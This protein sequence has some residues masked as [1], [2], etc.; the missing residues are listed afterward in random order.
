M[1]PIPGFMTKEQREAIPF[2]D[3]NLI[4]ENG[5]IRTHGVILYQQCG[6]ISDVMT[7]DKICRSFPL[8]FKKELVEEALGYIYALVLCQSPLFENEAAALRPVL[9]PRLYDVF[10]AL[11]V[12]EFAD[13][14]RYH[15]HCDIPESYFPGDVIWDEKIRQSTEKFIHF[16]NNAEE[17]C[18]NGTFYKMMMSEALHSFGTH[19]A[20]MGGSFDASKVLSSVNFT[21][22]QI[23]EIVISTF[24]KEKRDEKEVESEISKLENLDLRFLYRLILQYC[25]AN[26][27]AI[28]SIKQNVLEFIPKAGYALFIIDREKEMAKKYEE[29]FGISKSEAFLSDLKNKLLICHDFKLLYVETRDKVV[30]YTLKIKVGG[31]VSIAFADLNMPEE[32]YDNLN[33]EQYAVQ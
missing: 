4:C 29:V 14:Y 11:Q 7:Y 23:T 12:E 3:F 32:D 18:G 10:S 21:V 15:E 16:F 28:D 31:P 8:S 6:A 17:I 24:D 30:F 2:A 1:E 33:F 26:P 13:A 25:V 27:E 20:G 19:V 5:T 9:H 22:D